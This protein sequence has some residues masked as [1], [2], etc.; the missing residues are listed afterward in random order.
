M[1]SNQGVVP[2]EFSVPG[3]PIRNIAVAGSKMPVHWQKYLKVTY[4]TPVSRFKHK[5]PLYPVTCFIYLLPLL[6]V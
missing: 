1:A 3:H 2:N 4:K 5:F 6:V